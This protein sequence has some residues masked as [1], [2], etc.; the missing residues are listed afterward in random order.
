MLSVESKWTVFEEETLAVSATGKSV[1]N[2][3]S[4]LL[5]LHRRRHI[6]TEQDIR[7]AVVPGERVFWIERSKSAQK[8][9]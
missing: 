9:T 2:K 5:L 8:V 3:H 1:D 7:K 6:L 4:R